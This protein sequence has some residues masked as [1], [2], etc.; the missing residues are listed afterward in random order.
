V[1]SIVIIPFRRCT[2][3][4]D[5]ASS[6]FRS[7]G[8]GT[9]DLAFAAVMLPSTAGRVARQTLHALIVGNELSFEPLIQ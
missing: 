6:L 4:A 9:R 3:W 8:K 2:C 7:M 1:P 5:A